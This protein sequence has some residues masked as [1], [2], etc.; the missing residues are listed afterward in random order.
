[1]AGVTVL[2][3]RALEQRAVDGVGQSDGLDDNGH[4]AQ[5]GQ[6]DG[7]DGDPRQPRHLGRH[8][9]VDQAGP[10]P[11]TESAHG[12]NVVPFTEMRCPVRP[13]ATGVSGGGRI[14]G[15]RRGTGSVG[16]VGHHDA[17]HG[18][19]PGRRRRRSP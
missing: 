17:A 2:E 13:S 6:H 15:R 3:R 11:R 1:M 7:N 14:V 18:I 5:H 12:L 10:A 8:V 4:G 16:E 19:E 9:G